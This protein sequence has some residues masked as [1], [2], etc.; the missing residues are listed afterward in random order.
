MSMNTLQKQTNINIQEKAN[1]IWEIATHLVGLF[2]PHE[3]GKVILPMTVLKRFDDALAPTKDAVVA[4]GKKLAEMK[5]EGEARDGI[6]C[7][8]SGYSFYN[9]SKFDFKKLIAEPDDIES[10][11]ENYLQGFSSNVK[12]IISKFNFT[13]QVRTMANGNVLFVVIQEFVSAKGD[14]SPNKITSADMGYIFE[15][16]IRKFSESY[17]EQAGAHFTSRDII[18]LMT[19]LL[20]APEKA[21]I[22]ENG[23]TKTAYDMAMGTSQMLGCLTERLHEISEDADITCFG[24]EFNP[25]TYAIAKAD[26][27]IKGGNASGMMYGDTLND[28]KFSGYEFDY[29]ISN[30]PFGIDWKREK[31]EVEA[32]AKKGYEGRFG[33][34]LPSISDGQMLFM[35][36]GIK[37]LKEGSGRMAIIQNGSS[38]F[39]GDAGSGSSEIRR[40]VLEGDMVETIIQLPT[41][42]FYN[43][44]ISTYIWVIT[45]GKSVNRLGKVQ[46][47][48]ASKCYVKRRK[49]I[50]NKRVD[51]DDSCISLIME[52]YNDFAEKIYTAND[53]AVESKIFDNAFFGFTKVTVETAQTDENGKMILKKGNPQA[54]KG[55]SDTEIIP[56]GEDIDAYIQKNVLPYNPLAFLNR[57]KD[58]IGYEIPFTRLFYKFTA[59]VSSESI[60]DEIKE[61]E[62]E[63]NVLMKE[64]FGNE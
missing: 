31:T 58:K 27:L 4:M 24:E 7:K 15:E 18:Y 39:T 48:D 64:L 62:A 32:E 8:T 3:Y 21:E 55:A 57:K 5:V 40:Y 9:T 37:K 42:L 34:G 50:G 12:D 53:L 61:L 49:N 14:M 46:L 44:G 35:L 52:A 43:T 54:V 33:A 13:D 25:E 47:I 60:F 10:N 30:P 20:I 6:L 23:C 38:L 26:M 11:F 16:L 59:P 63:E 51:L 45:K 41:D 28:D 22:K 19:E 56:L 36:N 2:K 1:L 29:I 17:D